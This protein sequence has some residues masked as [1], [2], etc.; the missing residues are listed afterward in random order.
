MQTMRCVYLGA[1]LGLLALTGCDAASPPGTGGDAAVERGSVAADGA[2]RNALRDPDAYARARALGALLPT[3]GPEALPELQEVLGDPKLDIG[4]VESELLVRFWASHQPE[5]AT[6]WAADRSPPFHRNALVQTALPFW[7]AADLQAS[8]VASQEWQQLRPDIREPVARGLVLGWY[9]SGQPGL[10]QYIRDIGGGFERQLAL[11]TYLRAAIAKEGAEPVMRWA[12]AVPEDDPTYKL[13]VYRQVASALPLFDHDAAIRWCDSHC[14]GPFGNN[15]RNITAG[16]WVVVDGP[17]AFRWLATAP[18][19]HEKRLAIRSSFSAWVRMDP[20]AALAWMAQQ[21]AEGELPA[22]LAPVIPVYA[23]ALAERSPLEAVEWAQRIERERERE[24]TLIKVARLWRWADEAAA[25][26]WL[27]QS[28]L[29]DEARAKV[30]DPNWH[31]EGR[32]RPGR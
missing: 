7:V 13:T 9:A 26:A 14:D 28:P 8:L 12:E 22:W 4:G 2:I 15:L 3:L 6:R 18:D 5:A 1:A 27:E 21:G 10:Q 17:G 29:S 23:V 11:A 32:K 30:R 16:R 25:E 20:D 31:G 24:I 19:G